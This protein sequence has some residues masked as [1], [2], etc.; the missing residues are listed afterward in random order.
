[1]TYN[2]N[3]SDINTPPA[4][5]C[6]PGVGGDGWAAECTTA[7]TPN[8]S[9]DYFQEM[10][11]AFHAE[12]IRVIV[13]LASQG[14]AMFK[15][16]TSK[17]FDVKGRTTPLVPDCTVTAA[18]VGPA[19]CFSNPEN[20]CSQAL[21]NWIEYVKNLDYS[22]GISGKGIGEI[23]Y[24]KLHEAYADKIVGYYAL[25]SLPKGSTI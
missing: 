4:L 14:P 12:N 22:S 19:A 20:C 9:R 2:P 23:D 11:D 7:V 15:H 5:T 13:Y 10:L 1:M 8:N 6:E 18:N 21:G 16:G 25:V 24:P 3:L 17:A